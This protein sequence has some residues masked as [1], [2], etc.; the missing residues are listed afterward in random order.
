MIISKGL[1][2]DKILRKAHVY[3]KNELAGTITET[4][5]GYVFQYDKDFLKQNISISI[6]LPSREEPYRSKA[7]FSFFKGL[8]PEGWYLNIVSAVQKVDSNDDFGVLLSTTSM[9][10]I[11]A[12][13]VR[14]A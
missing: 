12:V 1:D 13:T 8:L 5:A 4:D 7:L 2:M 6:S 9:D 14:P 3:Y 10:T 11:G